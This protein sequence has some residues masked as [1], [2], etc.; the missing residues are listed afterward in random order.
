MSTLISFAWAMKKLLRSKAHFSILAGFI[1]EVLQE[2][3]TILRSWTARA[4]QRHGD[5][6]DYRTLKKKTK[7]PTDSVKR[8]HHDPEQADDLTPEEVQAAWEREM[9][10]RRAMQRE[11]DENV[12]KNC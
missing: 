6:W 5:Y 9:A 8:Q 3:L 2:D 11:V 10:A 7:Q 4:K 1:S 12:Q